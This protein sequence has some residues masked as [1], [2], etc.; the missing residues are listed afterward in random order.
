MTRRARNSSDHVQAR[1]AAGNFD[2]RLAPVERREDIQLAAE[3]IGEQ[4]QGAE[5]NTVAIGRDLQA[6]KRLLAHGTFVAWCEAEFGMSDS[7]AVRYIT[8]AEKGRDR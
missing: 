8:A 7:A 4:L 3:R 1:A 6:V 2:Y 5:Q